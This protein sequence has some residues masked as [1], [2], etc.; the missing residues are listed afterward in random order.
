MTEQELDDLIAHPKDLNF[1]A[2][3]VR[4]R[5]ERVKGANQEEAGE[6]VDLA[7]YVKAKV[8]E[9]LLA[10]GLITAPKKPTTRRKK[11]AE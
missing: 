11:K 6:Q 2:D 9:V 3:E 4:E 1:D 8:E 7:D 10:K 5:W